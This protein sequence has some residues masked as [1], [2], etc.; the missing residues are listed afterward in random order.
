MLFNPDN[1][2]ILFGELGTVQRGQ[3]MGLVPQCMAAWAVSAW[4][5]CAASSGQRSLAL[6]WCCWLPTIQANVLILNKTI[7]I[8]ESG[9]EVITKTSIREEN[10][11]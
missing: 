2:A 3:A 5:P 11:T 9:E 8:G 10:M 7:H 6:R 1:S 4:A